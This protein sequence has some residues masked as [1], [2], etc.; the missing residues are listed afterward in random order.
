MSHVTLTPRSI[1]NEIRL[2]SL[3]DRWRLDANDLTLAA[4]ALGRGGVASAAARLSAK[5]QRARADAD[6]LEDVSVVVFET[7]SALC[8]E[9]DRLRAAC[10]QLV[11]A[12]P[13]DACSPAQAVALAWARRALQDAACR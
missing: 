4:Q 2:K 9:F 3:V 6:E 8:H 5:A 1:A 11:N 12:L 13:E 7:E 10:Q